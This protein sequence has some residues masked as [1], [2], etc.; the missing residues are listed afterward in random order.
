MAMPCSGRTPDLLITN[1]KIVEVNLKHKTSN[2]NIRGFFEELA[3]GLLPRSSFP[4]GGFAPEESRPANYKFLKNIR[5]ELK[6]KALNSNIQGFSLRAG[7][8]T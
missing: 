1:F 2:T 3:E 4:I 5:G 8:G 6:N 7:R